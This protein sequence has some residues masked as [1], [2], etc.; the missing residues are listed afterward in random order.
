[1]QEAAQRSE[2]GHPVSQRAGGQK[3]AYLRHR[4]GDPRAVHAGSMVDA[5][6]DEEL[7]VLKQILQ[8]FESKSKELSIMPR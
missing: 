1:M 6:Q 4:C 5:I 2:E 8:N 7:A 3:L